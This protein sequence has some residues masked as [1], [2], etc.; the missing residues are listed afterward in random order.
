MYEE[1]KLEI[2]LFS[3]KDV[4]LASG[5]AWEDEDVDNNGWI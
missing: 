1:P 5:G 4:I 3:V 2:T